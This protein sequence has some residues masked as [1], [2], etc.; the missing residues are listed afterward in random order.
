VVVRRFFEGLEA[1][2]RI[3]SSFASVK[4]GL[5]FAR[6]V[7]AYLLIAN[8]IDWGPTGIAH[9]TI[10]RIFSTYN[11]IPAL[12]SIVPYDEP[13]TGIETADKDAGR[14]LF[15]A[16]CSGGVIQ[17][18]HQSGSAGAGYTFLLFG[19]ADMNVNDGGVVGLVWQKGFG[20]GWVQFSSNW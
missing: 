15:L 14:V 20:Q 17:L 2:C 12:H 3:M 4:N 13:A 9:A 18:K 5:F 1:R 8:T 7:D 10:L 16:N 11:G 19:H 6:P